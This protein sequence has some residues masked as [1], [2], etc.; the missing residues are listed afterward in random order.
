MSGRVILNKP[1][2]QQLVMHEGLEALFNL[3][4]GSFSITS[5]CKSAL[6]GEVAVRKQGVGLKIGNGI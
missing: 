5:L 4:G 1:H 2:R 6:R 3:I